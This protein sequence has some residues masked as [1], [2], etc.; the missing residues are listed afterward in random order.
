MGAS[1]LKHQR[2]MHKS[3]LEFGFVLSDVF[4]KYMEF[5]RRLWGYGIPQRI[6][7]GIRSLRDL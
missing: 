7:V 5:A 1:G 6:L 3:R 4:E 2:K